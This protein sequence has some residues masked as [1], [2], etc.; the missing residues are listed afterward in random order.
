MMEF[1]GEIIQIYERVRP[2]VT[3]TVITAKSEEKAFKDDN[4]VSPP[5]KNNLSLSIGEFLHLHMLNMSY[6]LC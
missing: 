5:G 3:R 2:P 6:F 1:P 4:F